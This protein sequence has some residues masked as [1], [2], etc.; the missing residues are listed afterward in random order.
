MR[1]T[2]ALLRSIP[3]PDH[4]ADSD[5]EQ[6]GRVLIVGGEVVLPGALVLAGIA[7]LRAGAGK[8]Q[9]VTCR[10]TAPLVGVLVP[11]CL[12]DGLDETKNGTISEKAAGKIIGYAKK[13]D[14]TLIGPGLRRSGE[15][16]RL[17]TRVLSEWKDNC[18]ILDAGALGALHRDPV[19]LH[20]LRGNAII[21]PHAG[22]M[23]DTLGI[24]KKEVEKDPHTVALNAAS[25]L[26]CVV[27]LKGSTTLIASP[28]GELFVY[29]SGDIGLA[30]SGS[31]DTLAGI[32]AG[33]LARGTSPLH[34][35]LWSVFLHGAAGNVLSKR[36]GRIGFLARELL[37]EIPP[38]MNRI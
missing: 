14:A 12:A 28:D 33:L 38:I 10:T 1:I 15:N 31:G 32:V 3:L 20:G 16:D 4:D 19:A 36:I 6:R 26:R 22:E 27:A 23:A 5:K 11:E 25:M 17:V 9:L 29:D 30:T 21:T 24:D 35:V 2:R 13:A 34:A 8:L 7:A 37:D 18:L